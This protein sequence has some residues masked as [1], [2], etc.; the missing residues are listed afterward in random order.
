MLK[1]YKVVRRLKNG[2]RVS[3]IATKEASLRKVYIHQ[4]VANV[5]ETSLVFGE[6][7]FAVSFK[8]WENS[9]CDYSL[10]VWEAEYEKTIPLPNM[11]IKMLT[12]GNVPLRYSPSQIKQIFD[13]DTKTIDI[14]YDRLSSRSRFPNFSIHASNVKLVKLIKK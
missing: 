2:D 1:C 4:G 6:L 7:E 3:A 12:Y 11:F 14:L 8:E 5:V 9:N 10:E 13:N